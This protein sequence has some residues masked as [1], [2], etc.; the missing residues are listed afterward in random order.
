MY[1]VLLSRTGVAYAVECDDEL[2]EF[3]FVEVL[4]DYVES[5]DVIMFVDS[6]SALK[7]SMEL[8]YKVEVIEDEE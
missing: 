2:N 3:D 7:D 8:E 5:G 6:L 1:R 4:R